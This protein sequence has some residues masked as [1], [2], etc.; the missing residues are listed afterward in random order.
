VKRKAKKS[1]NNATDELM[2]IEDDKKIKKHRKK[3]RVISS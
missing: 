2:G 1:V 3:R